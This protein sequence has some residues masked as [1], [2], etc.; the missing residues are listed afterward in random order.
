MTI[1]GIASS[2]RAIGPRAHGSFR[3]SFAYGFD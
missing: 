1:T 2:M 3:V